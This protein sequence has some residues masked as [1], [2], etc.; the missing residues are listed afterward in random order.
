MI[1]WIIGI[2]ALA[3]AGWILLALVAWRRG[4]ESRLNR[5]EGTAEETVA[6]LRELRQEIEGLRGA[7]PQ[8]VGR[9]EVEKLVRLGDELR[10]AIRAA[11]TAAPVSTTTAQVPAA[12]AD[13]E[14][15]VREH[16]LREGFS[17]FRIFGESTSTEEPGA[18]RVSL[19]A[20]RD[21]LEHKGHMLVREGMV[22]RSRL[23]PSYGVF[24]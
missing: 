20:L 11:P 18:T 17:D 5:L 3:V 10:E 6:T 4:F 22:V 14:T 23:L 1:G 8:D 15:C 9:R 2:I 19:R 7:L 12:P 13:V 24:P 21:G 16:L